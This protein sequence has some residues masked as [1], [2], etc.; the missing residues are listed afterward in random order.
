MIKI[1]G[2][3]VFRKIYFTFDKKIYIAFF[4]ILFKNGVG[5]YEFF[6][7]VMSM[8]LNDEDVIQ[9]IINDIKLE[10]KNKKISEIQI[11]KTNLYDL[12]ELNSAL[13]KIENMAES[14][15]EN[16]NEIKKII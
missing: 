10:R 5:I 9:K 3:K 13:N 11:S 8:A 2:D 4:K 1:K 16:D 14:N 15:E 7:H 12:M 6:M